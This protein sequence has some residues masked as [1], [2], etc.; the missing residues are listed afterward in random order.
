MPTLFLIELF[1]GS[2]SVSRTVKRAFGN[3]YR[4]RVLSCDNDPRTNPSILGDINKWRYK[5][6]IDDF[7]KDR[8]RNDIVAAWTSPPCTAFSLAN[9]TGVRDIAGGTRNVKKGLRIVRYCKPDIWFQEN[10]V[11]LLRK[12]PFM[13]RLRN[14]LNTCCYCKYGRPFKKP[15]NIWSN[16]PELNLKMCNSATPCAAKS[17]LGHH[18]VTAQSGPS[19][20]GKTRGSGNGR[21]VYPIPGRLVAELFRKGL[22]HVKL[23][24]TIGSRSTLL[25]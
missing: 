17:A 20:D 15:T 11:G 22:V 18:P 23:H 2:H 25:V 6:D 24:G 4:V 7:L 3:K 1:A 14:R 8:R 13:A 5:P 19:S 9:T 10:P 12:Q 21:N 16:V